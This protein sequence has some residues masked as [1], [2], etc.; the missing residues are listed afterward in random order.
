MISDQYHTIFYGDWKAYPIDENSLNPGDGIIIL[1]A[2]QERLHFAIHLIKG[3]YLSLFGSLSPLCA[4]NLD[5]MKKAFN[6]VIAYKVVLTPKETTID[7][8]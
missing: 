4:S 5:E 8:T 3:I 7:K 6:G 2:K 1:G